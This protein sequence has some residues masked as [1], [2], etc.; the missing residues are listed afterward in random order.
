MFIPLQIVLSDP[1]F[2]I[3]Q[4]NITSQGIKNICIGDSTLITA[5]ALAGSGSINK[6]EWLN[7]GLLIP[8]L[9]DSFAYISQAGAYSVIVSNSNGCINNSAVI[10]ISIYPYPVG[11]ISL[12]ISYNICEGSSINLVA[13]SG[14]NYNTVC[15]CLRNVCKTIF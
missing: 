3:P 6:Y 10:P 9:K 2:A 13:T 8:S 15:T 5:T 14:Y 12:P 11:N 4:I 1:V 7:N